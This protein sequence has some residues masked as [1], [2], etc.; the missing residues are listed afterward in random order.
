MNGGKVS[1]EGLKS[2]TILV[3]KA[4]NDPLK[5]LSALTRVGIQFTEQQ[6]AQIKTYSE[7]GDSEKAQGVILG[8][9]NT[10]Y[11]AFAEAIRHTHE[12]RMMAL[13]SAVG[14]LSEEFGKALAPALAGITEKLISLYTQTFEYIKN[15]N[16]KL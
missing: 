11:G 2:A 7:L 13:N 14:T 8:E 4:L 15:I 10:Q 6:K 12:G 3:G 1:V 9:L 5:G 16:N